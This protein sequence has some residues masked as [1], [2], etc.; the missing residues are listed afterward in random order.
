MQICQ[1]AGYKNSGKTTLMNQ[2][3]QYF[4]ETGVRVG[5]LKHHG[6]GGEP[7]LGKQTDSRQHLD[8][9]AVISGVQGETISQFM[10][11]Q[12]LDL[13]ELVQLYNSF[14][15]DL[16]LIEGF[17]KSAYPKIVLVRNR[18]D[19]A[20]INELPDVLAVGSRNAALLEELNVPV[21]NLNRIPENIPRLAE[22]IRGC[23]NE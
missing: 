13:D 21:F 9:G 19:L 20:L 4:S 12:Q 5:S 6:H 2:L 1:I 7:D 10:L 17:K 15:I 14:P 23:S 11:H 8:S 18:E 3:I 22:Y 16:L